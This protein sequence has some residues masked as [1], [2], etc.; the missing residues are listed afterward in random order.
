P[1]HDAGWGN[2][3]VLHHLPQTEKMSEVLWEFL[4]PYTP[5]APDREAMEKLLA[6][7]IVAWNVPL[8]PVGERAQRLR[9][10]STTLPA[11]ARTDFL[12]LIREMVARKEG[13][14]GQHPRY[15]LIY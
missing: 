13:D 3:T 1:L 12:A 15:I 9:E 2:Y 8:F 6:M 10:L 14:F 5:L 7:A 4:A 11:E